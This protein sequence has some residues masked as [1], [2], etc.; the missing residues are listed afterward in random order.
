MNPEIVGIGEVLVD[1]VSTEPVSYIEA[2]TFKKCFGGA[3]MNTLVGVTRLGSTAGAIT[4]VGDDPFGQFLLRE[5]KN[6][7]VDVSRVRIKKNARTTLAFVA[8]EP[9]T[10]ERTFIFYRTPWVRGTSVDALSSKDVDFGYISSSRILHVS[11]F[12]LSG[13]PSRRA[14]FSAIIH[15]R[16]EG[17]KVSF[18]PTLRL[19]VWR[20]ENVIRRIYRKVL[21]LSNIATFSR[22]ESEFMFGVQNPDEAADKALKHGVEVVGIKLGERGS[23]VKTSDGERIYMPAFKVKAVDTTGA[24]D[25]W[26]AGLLVGLLKG[27]D[28]EKCV[29][30]ANA[31][32]ALVVTKHGAITALPY[33]DEL[34]D[35]LKDQGL[36][37]RI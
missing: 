14:I 30:V 11:G 31:V 19:D 23:L 16:K 18:D 3:P 24:G 4:V 15:A 26:N 32:G 29:T 9:E 34:N 5:L 6:N 13:N 2:L 36:S 21:K 25:G 35:F 8:N 28:L 20:S 10:G 12:A 17:V 37:V 33:K 7:G 27:W 1:F 22:E